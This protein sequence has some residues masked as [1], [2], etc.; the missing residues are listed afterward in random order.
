MNLNVVR[1][2]GMWRRDVPTYTALCHK[3]EIFV[4]KFVIHSVEADDE[5]LEDSSK[6]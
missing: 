5:Q 3:T 2:S 6:C 1:Y 4:I